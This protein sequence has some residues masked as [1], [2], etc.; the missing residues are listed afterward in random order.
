MD[1]AGRKTIEKNLRKEILDLV[2][3]RELPVRESFERDYP[4]R[5]FLTSDGCTRLP[6][7]TE[8]S[9]C[10]LFYS[11]K[12][13]RFHVMLRELPSTENHTIPLVEFEEL[14]SSGQAAI[15]G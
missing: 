8:L 4:T 13:A 15:V 10:Q 14:L 5:R 11:L 2:L 1:A 9:Y 12:D 3:N 6:S 7:S